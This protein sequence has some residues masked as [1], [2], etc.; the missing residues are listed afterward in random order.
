[1]TCKRATV[2]A[3]AALGV[4]LTGLWGLHGILPHPAP[5]RA[6]DAVYSLPAG[7][8]NRI[9]CTIGYVDNRTALTAAHCLGKGGRVFDYAGHLVGT[10]QPLTGRDI[11]LIRR[12]EATLVGTRQQ[13]VAARPVV[14]GDRVCFTSRVLGGQSCGHVVSVEDSLA[15]VAPALRGAPGDSGG[16]VWSDG[17]FAGVY[18]GVV[19]SNSGDVLYSTVAIP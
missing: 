3:V 10:G 9:S 14:A 8:A 13:S 6:G 17:G 2:G 19:E 12:P 4:C 16:A 7:T 15:R 1:M 11:A 5:L 18:T